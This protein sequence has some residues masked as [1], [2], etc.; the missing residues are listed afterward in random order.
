MG[1]AEGESTPAQI[2]GL[3]LAT[4]MQRPMTTATKTVAKSIKEI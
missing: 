2:A 1:E 4:S 3:C